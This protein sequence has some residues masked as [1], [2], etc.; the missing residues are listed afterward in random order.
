VDTRKVRPDA[1]PEDI[2]AQSDDVTISCL[3]LTLENGGRA[4]IAWL[5]DSRPWPPA[6]TRTREG[7]SILHGTV[8]FLV[9]LRPDTLSPPSPEPDAHAAAMELRFRDAMRLVPPALAGFPDWRRIGRRDVFLTDGDSRAV[10]PWAVC[11]VSGYPRWFAKRKAEA[12]RPHDFT[13]ATRRALLEAAGHRCQRCGTRDRLAVDHIV[14]IMLGGTKA[15]ENGLVLCADCHLAKTRAERAAFGL[16][17][18]PPA[19]AASPPRFLAEL[20]ALT[21]WTLREQGTAARHEP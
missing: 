16:W 4:A 8:P 20:A 9:V 11:C 6:W 13:P 17:R 21:G 2:V 3:R 5:D 14:P 12:R 15:P 1:R 18:P 7:L 10:P 19:S